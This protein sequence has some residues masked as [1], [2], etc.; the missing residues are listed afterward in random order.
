[1]KAIVY[2]QYGSLDVLQ[3]NDVAKPTP[4][5]NEVL[6]HIHAAAVTVG[7]VIII[8]ASRSRSA[9]GPDF[10]HQNTRYPEKKWRGGSK[11]LARTSRSFS[12]VMR[13]SGISPC[14]VW[15]RLPRMT[16]ILDHGM[17]DA[18]DRTVI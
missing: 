17:T 10:S 2:T 18:I 12:R 14:V 15:A 11:R 4:K 3:C 8:K 9:S 5:D 7:D 1:M 6:V 13:Y 16:P